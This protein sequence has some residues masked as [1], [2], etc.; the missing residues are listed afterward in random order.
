MRFDYSWLDSFIREAVPGTDP[1]ATIGNQLPQVPSYRARGTLWYRGQP[2]WS[3]S[4]NVALVG[5]QFEDDLND[6]PLA[7][8]VTVGAS[9]EV[10]LFASVRGTIRAE[11]LFNESVEVRRAPV[12][13]YGAPRLIYAGITVGFPR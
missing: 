9:L 3:A 12:L 8:A 1:A 2:S 5:E 7:S 4:F 6:R 10:P 11:N 13:V